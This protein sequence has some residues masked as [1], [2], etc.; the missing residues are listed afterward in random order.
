[1][2]NATIASAAMRNREV[3]TPGEQAARPTAMLDRS[4]GELPS[5]LTGTMQVPE[6]KQVLPA[7]ASPASEYANGS[8]PEI[9][10][11]SPVSATTL[12]QTPSRTSVAREDRKATAPLRTQERFKRYLYRAENARSV[13][14]RPQG[15]ERES[16]PV[17]SSAMALRFPSADEPYVNLGVRNR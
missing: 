8:P 13:Q 2:V 12:D 15:S 17:S 4:P 16:R 3:E 1:L 9:A 7:P 11:K 5:E 10:V 14:G 6:G